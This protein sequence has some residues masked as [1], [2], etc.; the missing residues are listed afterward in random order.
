MTNGICCRQAGGGDDPM[1]MLGPMVSEVQSRL[2]YIFKTEL[3]ANDHA[4]LKVR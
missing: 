1:S 2:N 4:S 3:Q